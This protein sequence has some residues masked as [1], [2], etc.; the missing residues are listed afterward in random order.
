LWGRGEGTGVVL[1]IGHRGVWGHGIS[2][3]W[4]LQSGICIV[5]LKTS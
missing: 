5:N 3:A 4:P 2:V 1:D